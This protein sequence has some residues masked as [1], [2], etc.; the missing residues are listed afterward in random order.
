MK[1][2]I[3]LIAA[4]FM[5]WQASQAQTV[6]VKPTA[7]QATSFAIVTDNETYHQTENSLLRYRDAVEKDGLATYIIRGD[8]KNPTEVK[9]Q[10]VKVY[11]EA[12]HLEGIVLVGDIPVALVRNAQ[13]FTT[14]FKMNEAVYPFEQS[15][16]PTDRFYDALDLEFEFLRPDSINPQHFYY[17]LKE[18]SPQV[19]RPTFYSARIKYP[20]ARGGDKYKAIAAFLDKAAKAKERLQKDQLDQVVSYNGSS[21]NSDCLIAWM[22]EERAYK[23]NFPLAF[24][25]STSFKHWNFRMENP[26]KYRLF[27]ELQRP[28]VDV[29]MFHEH[30][31]PTA[32]LINNGATGEDFSSR[33]E[34]LRSELYSYVQRM[35]RRKK[36]AED[37][38][39]VA[40]EKE[41]GLKPEFWGKMGTPE[42]IKADSLYDGIQ[43][44][45]TEDMLTRKSNPTFVMF[46][47]CYNGS[48]HEDD[49][50][51]GSYIF[52][53][54][55]TLV[56]QG[57]T[58]N[59]LQDR[60]TIEM[61]GL[62]SHGIRVGH[63][64]RLIASLEGH[65]IGDP[66]VRFAPVEANDLSASIST[67]AADK[68]YWEGQLESPYA[69]V[70]SLALRML[71][72][73]DQEKRL[74]D[75]LYKT[76]CETPFITVRA[77]ALRL[78]SRY[79]DANFTNAVKAGISDSYER[80]ARH[81]SDYANKM[82][83]PVLLPAMVKA[84]VDES[85]RQR[86]QYT[87]MGA[88]QNFKWEDV[89][90]ATRAYFATANRVN[91]EQEEATVLRIFKR[92]IEKM[93]KQKANMTNPELEP[94]DRIMN[95]R[96]W[97]NYPRHP[98]I[99]FS[100]AYIGDDSNPLDTRVV[101]AEVLGWYHLSY[102]KDDIVK[103]LKALQKK[104]LPDEVQAE[105]V[106]TLRR[107][108][109]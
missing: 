100:L 102:R 35:A 3:T 42:Q 61:I 15:S 41:F 74:S 82:G 6:V 67:R 60:W 80:L 20:V 43:H 4:L 105:I 34:R 47:A 26:M 108:E 64:N 75:M 83:D 84:I 21:Y 66:T 49:Y 11:K 39:R 85:E 62:L 99:D 57:N 106:Q 87:L 18:S 8:W 7:E 38:I 53:G 58:R 91:K 63:Y 27:D 50:I 56:A 73:H 52:S 12:N 9:E 24:K 79:R 37:T 23:E 16:V 76:Y 22:D 32:Q 97:R 81:A 68:A 107:I 51:A 48:F 93:D 1:S 29:F 10:I 94:M 55:N 25:T 2:K 77:E 88:I 44:I 17:K 96:T 31:M 13:H 54:G 89:E 86:V 103:G 5:G 65:L 45:T 104:T 72:D 36:V 30:G 109:Y 98:E 46:D 69:D 40:L 92:S 33:Y 70:R 90:A 14:A 28:D 78:L 95:M 101:M 19:L 71:A 59:V